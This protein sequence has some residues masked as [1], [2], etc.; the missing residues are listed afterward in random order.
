LIA[1]VTLTAVVVS[2]G[3]FA[4]A[5][6]V[7]VAL[8]MAVMAFTSCLL[9]R[10]SPVAEESAAMAVVIWGVVSAIL[11]VGYPLAAKE[12][13]GGWFVAWM[14][15]LVSRRVNGNRTVWI[16]V[17]V[18]AAATMVALAV[19]AEGVGAQ[20]IRHGGL[21]VNPNVVAALLV[22]VVPTMWLVLQPRIGT[23]W[24]W[25]L[26]GVTVAG[27]VATG[28]R[29]GLLAL[30]VVLAAMLPA[31]RIR[32]A[33]ALVAAVAAAG[34]L[35]WR[36]VAAPDSLAWHRLEIWRALLS[37]VASRPLVGVGPGWLEDATGVVRI[38]DHDSLARFGHVIGSAESTPVGILVRVGVVGFIAAAVGLAL[39]WRRGRS[40]GF[41]HRPM[42]QAVV[43]GIAVLALF[44]DY[45]DVDVV[46]WWWAVV[47][48]LAV[49]VGESA[50]PA[51]HRPAAATA[52]RVV[53]GLASAALVAWAIGQP[54][55]ARH[56][57][58][59]APSTA[60]LAER[61]IRAELWFEEPASW[62]VREELQRQPWSW[63]SAAEAMARS[64]H[65]TTVRPGSWRVWM[66]AGE[67]HARVAV[68]LGAWPETID[69]AR[70]CFRRSTE[71]EPHL[72]W[73]WLRWARL[74]RSVGR[75]GEARRLA[76]RAV[77]EEPNFVRGQL[78]L[79]R[80]ALDAGDS[81]T[82]VTAFEKARAAHQLGDARPLTEYQR[83]LIR[84][85][86]WQV[87]EIGRALEASSTA[88]DD[89]IQ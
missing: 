7:G 5:E 43:V 42:A 38:A 63:E 51:R 77:T 8:A 31:G 75:P 16:G 78:F 46:L 61:S 39:W 41:L 74:E 6:R 29:A 37:L 10:R 71:L 83:D 18:T 12:M 24:L 86:A 66:D 59:S 2:G 48:G 35:T 76:E 40:A 68:D 85:P 79:A 15:W 25:M 21:F 9:L 58:W 11:A 81:G 47:I 3:A 53:A 27:M 45:L 89:V 55:F 65:A 70:R 57:W 50:A 72:P 36:F 80:L 56:L 4:P 54:A 34:V 49:P 30:V 88:V 60:E 14:L 73:P 52:P 26:T 32:W 64:R 62:R 87:E 23:S 82:A 13:L 28:S 1:V 84:A 44:H 17:A 22:P 69:E 33:G 20:A 19:L 67:V